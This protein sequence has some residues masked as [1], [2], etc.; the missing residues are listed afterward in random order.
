MQKDRRM[1][2]DFIFSSRAGRPGTK[3]GKRQLA[4]SEGDASEHSCAKKATIETDLVR[5]PRLL[6]N[7][8]GTGEVKSLTARMREEWDRLRRLARGNDTGP[9]EAKRSYM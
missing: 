4:Q 9:N 8:F 1:G 3:S 6:A 2:S 5:S 7:A